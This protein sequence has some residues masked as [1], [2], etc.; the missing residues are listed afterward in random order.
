M[1]TRTASGW[2]NE[3]QR[4]GGVD[5]IPLPAD[6]PGAL[7]LC[8]KQAVATRYESDA[9][10][11]IVCLAERHELAGHLPGYVAW[12]EQADAI[13]HPVHDLHA[14]PIEEMQVLVERIVARVR[15]G[16]RVL[17]HC[18]AGKG[19]AGTTAVCVLIALGHDTDEALRI[20]ADARPG[21]GPEAG[22]QLALVHRMGASVHG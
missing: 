9:W 1:S 4:D 19:R 21:A 13:W 17:M 7:W 11:T 2:L 6:V 10:D 18:A 5:R 8:G 16:D 14:P 12:L 15:R 3:R 20:V 22:V